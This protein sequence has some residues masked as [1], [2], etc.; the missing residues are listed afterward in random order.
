MPK[1][2]F[3]PAPFSDKPYRA[4]PLTPVESHQI[5]AIGYDAATKTLAVTF[6]RGSGTV[7]HYPNV[8]PALHADFM[9]AES[10]GRFFDAMVRPIAFEKF[11]V[12]EPA[13]DGA[14]AA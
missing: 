8:E 1:K 6:N 13:K 3:T 14:A 5:A 9:A 12:P 10:K 7:Y 4:I 2:D 11:R